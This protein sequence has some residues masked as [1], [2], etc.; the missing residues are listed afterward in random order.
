[1]SF[2]DNTIAFCLQVKSVLFSHIL[3]ENSL[4]IS[5]DTDKLLNMICRAIDYLKTV[6][7]GYPILKE[8]VTQGQVLSAV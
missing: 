7:V 2:E 4:V 3:I 8:F 5:I 6:K 1:M